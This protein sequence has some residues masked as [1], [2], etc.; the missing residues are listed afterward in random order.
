MSGQDVIDG[1][2]IVLAI[3]DDDRILHVGPAFTVLDHVREGTDPP[4]A[5]LEFYDYSARRLTVVGGDLAVDHSAPAPD[6]QLLLDR[7]DVVQARM[8]VALDRQPLVP[9][10]PG[11]RVM[12]R[13]PRVSGELPE[14]LQVLAFLNGDLPAVS[15]P[16]SGPPWHQVA[17]LFGVAH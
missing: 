13:L 3:A 17:H 8:Q 4:P 12:T 11:D 2:T 15:D 10:T 16:N 6:A 9:D 7:I 1:T 5:D 14:V